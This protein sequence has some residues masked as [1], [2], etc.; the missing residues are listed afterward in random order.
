MVGGKFNRPILA[1]AM[2]HGGRL[3][4]QWRIARVR[5]G[6]GCLT[7]RKK[8]R[9]QPLINSTRNQRV[10][11]RY[12]FW[13]RAE[14]E[15]DRNAHGYGHESYPIKQSCRPRFEK[16]RFTP[17]RPRMQ[18]QLRRYFRPLSLNTQAYTVK[19]SPSACHFGVARRDWPASGELSGRHERAG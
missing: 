12:S 7:C 10:V 6:K 11:S 17:A 5:D 18:C 15:Y 4:V 14:N 16:A 1:V 9:V 13:H 19:A 3:R 8:R 2:L